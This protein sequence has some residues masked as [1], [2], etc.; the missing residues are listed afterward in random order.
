MFFGEKGRVNNR[1]PSLH[2]RA[3]VPRPNVN[4]V[5]FFHSHHCCTAFQQLFVPATCLTIAALHKRTRA[6]A[7]HRKREV[8]FVFC[9][10]CQLWHTPA[11]HATPINFATTE[12]Q[13]KNKNWAQQH[14]QRESQEFR[15]RSV[16]YP[17]L[18]I[19]N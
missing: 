13:Q 12:K 17:T 18:T 10:T 1:F 7:E 9:K 19:R 2:P 11:G 4:K 5:K 6:A 14:F 16:F 8:S 15:G 3:P